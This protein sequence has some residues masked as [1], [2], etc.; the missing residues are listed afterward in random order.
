MIGQIQTNL[1]AARKTKPN[2]IINHN[3]HPTLCSLPLLIL[4][5]LRPLTGFINGIRPHLFS[6]ELIWKIGVSPACQ[7]GLWCRHC[8]PLESLKQRIHVQPGVAELHIHS[9]SGRVHVNNFALNGSI[10]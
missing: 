4:H 5:Y 3:F 2:R 7:I 9:I 1:G 10:V 8:V 6:I